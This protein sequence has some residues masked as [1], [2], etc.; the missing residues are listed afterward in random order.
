MA[1][2]AVWYGSTTGT[3]EALASLVAEKLGTSDVFCVTDLTADKIAAYDVLVLGTST[4]GD[5]E[6]Q[7]DWYDGVEVL[8]SADLSAKKVA[9]FGCGDAASYPDTFCSAMGIIHEACQGA[10]IIGKG[11]PTDGYTFGDSLAVV[12]GTWIGCA[13]DDMNESEK[14]EERINAW[15][16]KVKS[17]I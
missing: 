8:K 16:D 11:L 15:V 9:L 4:W 10:T 6:L 7:D 5:G 1:K 13:L 12:D 17:E 2:I 3:C 14:N